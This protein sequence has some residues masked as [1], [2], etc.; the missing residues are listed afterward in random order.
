MLL[1][2]VELRSN[3]TSLGNS[4][5]LDCARLIEIKVSTSI[6]VRD[7]LHHTSQDLLI[8]GQQALLYVIT[9]NV[10]ENTTEILEER[11]RGERARVGGHAT[12]RAQQSEDAE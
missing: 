5:K 11:V 2:E 9:E 8:V 12:E 6:V 7:I 4:S 1:V 10:A 3:S